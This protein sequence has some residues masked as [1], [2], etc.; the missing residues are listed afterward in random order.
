MRIDWIKKSFR[1]NTSELQSDNLKDQRCFLFKE[2]AGHR[3]ICNTEGSATIEAQRIK[4][5][6]GGGQLWTLS[7]NS[8]RNGKQVVAFLTLINFRSSCI[9]SNVI[10]GEGMGHLRK[11]VEGGG[12]LPASSTVELEGNKKFQMLEY[13][14]QNYQSE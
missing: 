2:L 3:R 7:Q 9:P 5:N 1:Q 8:G 11:G 14:Q 4:L 12:E 6:K 13:Q 10:K